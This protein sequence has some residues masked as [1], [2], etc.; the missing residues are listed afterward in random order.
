MIKTYLSNL[1]KEALEKLGIDNYT[2]NLDYPKNPENGDL[3][4]N[5]AM[6]LAKPLKKSPKQIAQDIIDNLRYDK[7]LIS[8]IEI[9]GNGFINFTFSA[10]FYHKLLEQIANYGQN[11]GKQEIGR[12]KKVIVEYVS[13][14]PTGLLHLG[15]GRNAIIGDTLANL[16]EWLGYDVTREYYFNNAGNQMRNLAKSIYAR[17]R[18]I[19]DNP[20][21]P[22]PEDGYF[23]DYII[24]IA[25]DFIAK[26]GNKV[27]EATDE[28]LKVFQKF[29]EEW[30]FIGIKNTLNRL[31][32]NQNSY[33]NENSLYE[34]GK[35]K[36]LLEEL[37]QKDLTY[38]K[39]G[40]IWLKLTKLGLEDDR[41]A[42]KATGEPTYRL[43]DIAY[44]REKFLRGFDEIVDI[45]GADHIATVPDVLATVKALGF[46]TKKVKV[47]I[48]QFVTLTENGQQVKMSKRSGK[49]YTLDELIDEVGADVVRFFLLMR[50]VNTHLEFDL[51]LAK[52]QSDKNPV[53]Y[54]QYAYARIS[55]IL[56]KVKEQEINISNFIDFS[57]LKEK[58]EL[59]LIKKIS[60]FPKIIY[61]A[62]EKSEPHILS[63]YLKELATI[64]H[65]FY[66]H[67]R[68]I[69]ES[70]GIF[71][72][73]LQLA[74]ITRITI[75]N[76]LDILGISAPEKM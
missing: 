49:S 27:L 35:I 52:E 46:D 21:Y 74:K 75:K 31:N 26:N 16:Y 33:F 65:N 60:D 4:T 22:F 18:Q 19:L 54:L 14:N 38:E 41:V 28:N 55:S 25:K 32:I 15:H 72:A 51:N 63:D 76:G 44:H 24:Q 64:F 45:F 23:G 56:Q 66:H 2:L 29:G 13:A 42:V 47:V 71:V 62:C 9:A 6:T 48:H 73:R 53:F 17:Y 68:I 50:G 1:L 57:K 10:V 40:A 11:F 7:S 67:C 58:V 5:I 36:A 43:P 34:D 30:N 39:D 12:N 70:E 61:D 59:D 37:R 8:K 3:S 69:G 20:D